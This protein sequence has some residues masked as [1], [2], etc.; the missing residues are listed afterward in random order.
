M[1]VLTKDLPLLK[2]NENG[3]IIFPSE[4]QACIEQVEIDL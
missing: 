4:V 2:P 3:D 1:E